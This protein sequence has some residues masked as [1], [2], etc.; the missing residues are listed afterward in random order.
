MMSDTASHS[1]FVEA[2]MPPRASVCHLCLRCDSAGGIAELSCQGS[3]SDLYSDHPGLG[4]LIAH[5]DHR[6]S[7]RHHR[8]EPGS[9]FVIIDQHCCLLN[10]DLL[11]I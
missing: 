11:L 2:L 5:A 9:R 1:L 3:G 8:R 7:I 6:Q 4:D 10:L